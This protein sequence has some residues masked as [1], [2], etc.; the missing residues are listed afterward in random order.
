MYYKRWV[1]YYSYTRALWAK[2]L[3]A[4]QLL[5]KKGSASEIGDNVLPKPTSYETQ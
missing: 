3:T 4:C 2:T 5:R 1:K